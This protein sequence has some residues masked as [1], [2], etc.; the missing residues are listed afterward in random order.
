VLLRRAIAAFSAAALLATGAQAAPAPAKVSDVTFVAWNVRNYMM[1]PVKNRDGRVMT[2]AKPPESA[3]AVATTLAG[4]KP[5]IVGLSEIGTRQDLENLQRRLKKLGVDL[6]HRT[7]VNGADRERHL[8]LLSR[9]PL[10]AA[11]DTRSGFVLGGLPY[12]VQRGFL[13]A[14]LTICPGFD[15][16]ILGAHFKSR[17][18]V[19]EFDQAEFRRNESLLLRS[20]ID[21]ILRDDPATLLLLFG[22][23]NDNKNSPAVAGAAGRRGGAT[24]LEILE[25]ADKVGDQW[26]YHW[27]E[28]DEYSRVDYAMASKALVPLVRKKKSMVYRAARWNE[29]SDHRPLV[30]IIGVP[31]TGTKK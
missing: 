17:R 18:I 24:S 15:L 2:P 20:K 25:L 1:S 29:A 22:D 19:P 3:Q 7:W 9:F 4:L 31:A 13:D 21:G 14:T 10:R 30:V 27:S 28:S 16:R 12:R 23:L 11:H 6:P 5:D 8:A 26:T